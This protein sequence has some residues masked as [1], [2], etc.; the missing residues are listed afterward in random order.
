M[1]GKAAYAVYT[2][3]GTLH[4]IVVD[5]DQYIVAASTEMGDMSVKPSKVPVST[6]LYEKEMH[7][8]MNWRLPEW[9]KHNTY[10]GGN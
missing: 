7:N 2:R 3:T 5:P 9:D 10:I 4:V 8:V 6:H 1:K